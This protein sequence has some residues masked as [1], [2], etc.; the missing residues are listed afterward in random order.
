M[1]LFGQEQTLENIPKNILECL[2]EMGKDTI[3]TLNA[4]ESKYLNF[5]F[6]KN[7]GIFDFSG[8]KNSIF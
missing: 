8:K 1:T 2:L 5:D 4:C 7:R 3:P 6:Q